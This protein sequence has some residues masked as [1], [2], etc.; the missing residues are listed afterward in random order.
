ML[1]HLRNAQRGGPGGDPDG[2]PAGSR[3]HPSG[4]P[5]YSHAA[6]RRQV[7]G[8]VRYLTQRFDV[9]VIGSGSGLDVANGLASRGMAVAIV[10]K[11]PLGGTCLNRGCIPSKMRLHSADVVETIRTANLFGIHVKGYD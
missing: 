7:I 9:I 8:S 6:G 3:G 11:G 5:S 4:G 1:L 10:E 2:F